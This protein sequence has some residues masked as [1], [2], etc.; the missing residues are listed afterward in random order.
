MHGISQARNMAKTI[1]RTAREIIQIIVYK[2]SLG[3]QHDHGTFVGSVNVW[4][5]RVHLNALVDVAAVALS[6]KA[7]RC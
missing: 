2:F 5:L 6:H 7:A 1:G 3:I 4:G